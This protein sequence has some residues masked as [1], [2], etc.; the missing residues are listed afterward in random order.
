MAEGEAVG[1][2]HL[3]AVEVRHRYLRR[4]HEPEIVLGV[5]VEVVAELGQVTGADQAVGLDHRGWIDL[6]V[7]VL[8]GVEIEHP[9]D[10]RALQPRPGAAQ[11]VEA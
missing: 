7:A 2:Q 9:R 5:A 1:L 11:H 3:L 4:R 6:R 8:T 10:E